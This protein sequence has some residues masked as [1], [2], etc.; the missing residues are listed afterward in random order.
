MTP[1]PQSL[2][3]A[4]LERVAE[5]V[6]ALALAGMVIAVFV[7]VVLRYGFGMG[8]VYYEEL[9]R[10]LLVWMVCIGAVLASAQGKHLGFDMLTSRLSGWPARACRWLSQALVALCLV[11]VAKGS[12]GQVVAG[13][14]SFSTVMGYPLALAAAS[15]LVMALAMAVLLVVEI[16]R[17]APVPHHETDAGV[18]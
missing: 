15:T 8:I 5:R 7:N 3:P 9:S 14:Q 16:V 18:E 10:L 17:G 4:W 12:W 1:Q 2:L 6:M 11:L 13:M